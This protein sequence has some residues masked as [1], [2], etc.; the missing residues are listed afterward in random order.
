MKNLTKKL[1]YAIY[2]VLVAFLFTGCIGNDTVQIDTDSRPFIV[3]RI[4]KYNETH[5]VYV[6]EG[7]SDEMMMNF[8]SN[9]PK[10]VAPKGSFAMGDTVRFNCN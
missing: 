1:S 7:W 6:S 5:E 2:I 8:F 9:Y 10:I 4:E 3:D